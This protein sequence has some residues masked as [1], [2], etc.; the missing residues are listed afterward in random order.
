MIFG[1]G[2]ILIGG[3]ALYFAITGADPVE[4]FR[5][6]LIG[7]ASPEPLK[8]GRRPAAPGAGALPQEFPP[9]RQIKPTAPPD[10]D[11]TPQLQ[12]GLAVA[13]SVPGSRLIQ[14]CGAGSV[15]NSEH[16]HCNAADIGGPRPIL[17]A[18]F[19]ALLILARAGGPIHCIIGPSTNPAW[20]KGQIRSRES[21][22]KPSGYTGP[23][24]HQT[25]VHFSGWPSVGGGC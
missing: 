21:G 16:P 24:S 7:E 2:F 22:W 5:R 19:N 10:N 6:A 12:P 3:F 17:V 23:N 20:P 11:G 18:V 13:L 8:P 14:I 9:G 1:L 25:H 4:A 15:P